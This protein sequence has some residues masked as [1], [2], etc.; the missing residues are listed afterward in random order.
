MQRS[1]R[2]TKRKGRIDYRK[3]SQGDT[4]WKSDEDVKEKPKKASKE[5]QNTAGSQQESTMKSA[6]VISLLTY[7]VPS[8]PKIF[9]Q[10]Q[11]F[12]KVFHISVMYLYYYIWYHI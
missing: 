7:S 3:L 6:P 5:K 2:R 11:C 1:G 12:S 4:D 8:C 10:P 9:F